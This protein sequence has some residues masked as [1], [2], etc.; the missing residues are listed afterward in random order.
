MNILLLKN[1]KLIAVLVCVVLAVSAWQYDHAAQYKRGR[2]S[3]AAEI[4]GRLKDAAIEKAKQDRESSAVY[5]AGKAVR[6]EKERV[7][8]VQVQKIVEKP[9]YRNV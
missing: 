1:W 8:Y 7:R 6:E 4:S 9:V 5:Q 3:M 2:E